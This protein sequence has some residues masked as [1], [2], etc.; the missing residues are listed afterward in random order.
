MC[1]F[2]FAPESPYYLVRRGRLDEARQVLR[3]IRSDHTTAEEIDET[4]ALI[5]YTNQMEMENEKASTYAE[6]FKG[7]NLWRLE[8]V[9]LH[10]IK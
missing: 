6:C 10:Y 1:A 7:K 9:S 4:I 5:D 2:L 3:K 8:I